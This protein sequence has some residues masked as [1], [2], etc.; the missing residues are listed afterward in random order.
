MWKYYN[1]LNA[2]IKVVYDKTMDYLIYYAGYSDYPD[3]TYHPNNNQLTNILTEPTNEISEDTMEDYDDLIKI[4]LY[5]KE[6][7]GMRLYPAS[8]Y[9][10]EYTTFFGEPTFI[11]DNIYLGSAFNA[12]SLETLKKLNIKI[13]INATSE[14]SDY[15]PN[16][17]KYIRYKLYDNNKTSIKKYLEKSYRDIKK[18]NDGNIL[19]HCFMGASRSAS[20]ILFYLMKEKKHDNGAPFTFDDALEYLK[21]KRTIVNPTFRLTKD[22][23]SSIAQ[24][25]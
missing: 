12:A 10:D 24:N 21:N 2:G 25:N 16:E 5:E 1:F 7:T 14:I 11:T 6:N 8:N 9:Y 23:A 22:L 4:S 20:I 3:Y 17:F 15:Y 13:I 18:N 19:I